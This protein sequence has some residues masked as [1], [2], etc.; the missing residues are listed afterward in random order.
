MSIYVAFPTQRPEPQGQLCQLDAVWCEMVVF[1][2]GHRPFLHLT[3]SW[4]GY[5]CHSFWLWP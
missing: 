2:S 3:G 4:L 1:Y 5:V